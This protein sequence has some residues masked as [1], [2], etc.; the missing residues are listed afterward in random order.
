M[1]HAAKLGK[2]CLLYPFASV[3]DRCVLG[4][5]VIGI[6]DTPI[7]LMRRADSALTGRPAAPAAGRFDYVGLNHLGWLRSVTVDGVDRLPELRG[8]NLACWCKPGSPC[9]ADVLLEIANG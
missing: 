9:H 3:R 7:G 4:D 5:R 1:G 8:K 6:C 2:G